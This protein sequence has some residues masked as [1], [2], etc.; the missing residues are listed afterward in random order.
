[1]RDVV[2]DAVVPASG[3]LYVTF[4]S[5]TPATLW[6]D[7]RLLARRPYAAGG[8]LVPRSARVAATRGGTLRLVVRAGS[9]R[10]GERVLMAVGP[11]GAP[12]KLMTPEP[13]GRA[14]AAVT[15]ATASS[16]RRDAHRGVARP[17]ARRARDD[18]P[19]RAERALEEASKR[20]DAPGV[21]LAYGRALR[22]VIDLPPVAPASSRGAFGARAVPRPCGLGGAA[23]IAGPRRERRANRSDGSRPRGAEAGPSARGPRCSTPTPRPRRRRHAQ[24]R[25]TTSPSPIAR[26]RRGPLRRRA[27][28]AAVGA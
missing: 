2:V 18:E 5:T 1:M 26:R 10:P 24:D 13:G 3:E 4:A 19:R 17:R 11:D 23:E 27:R 7:G 25:V 12:A 8:G 6:A 21:L 14:E 16:A 28:G 15:A 22:R 20:E 9:E